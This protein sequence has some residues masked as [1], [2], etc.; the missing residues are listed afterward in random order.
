MDKLS[1][2]LKNVARNIS[3]QQRI[4]F[5]PWGRG[6]QVKVQILKGGNSHSKCSSKPFYRFQKSYLNP[7][8]R[9]RPEKSHIK[10]D[11]LER[12]PAVDSIIYLEI[13]TAFL[14]NA[15]S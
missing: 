14:Q 7:E 1:L 8:I 9:L 4:A 12:K 6:G 5:L 10:V 11:S 15:S 2:Q 3:L 13:K